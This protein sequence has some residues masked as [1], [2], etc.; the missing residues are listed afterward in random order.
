M[1]IVMHKKKKN[2]LHQGHIKLIKGDINDIYNVT[3]DVCFKLMLSLNFLFIKNTS[4]YKAAKPF[5]AL[6]ICTINNKWAAIIIK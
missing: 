3:K 4:F 6:I 1:E 2:F 5:S